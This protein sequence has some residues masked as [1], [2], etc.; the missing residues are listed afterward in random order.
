MVREYNYT[1]LKGLTLVSTFISLFLQQFV[2][3]GHFHFFL[4]FSEAGFHSHKQ[5]AATLTVTDQVI[6]GKGSRTSCSLIIIEGSK[7]VS[8][9]YPRQLIYPTGYVIPTNPQ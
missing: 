3:N 9:V 5:K 2:C 4:R 8:R 7:L 1:V 6:V